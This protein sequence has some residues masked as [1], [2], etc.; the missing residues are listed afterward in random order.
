MVKLEWD[1]SRNQ[2]RHTCD[3]RGELFGDEF[4]HLFEIRSCTREGF[5]TQPND[6]YDLYHKGDKIQ[7]GKTVKELKQRAELIGIN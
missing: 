1:Y 7:H 5:R 4:F 6:G 2:R 3:P